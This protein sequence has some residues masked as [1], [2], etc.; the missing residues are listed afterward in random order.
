MAKLERS[1]HSN[2]LLFAKTPFSVIHMDVLQVMPV[3]QGSF[4]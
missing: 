2:P 3:L 4:R 1:A